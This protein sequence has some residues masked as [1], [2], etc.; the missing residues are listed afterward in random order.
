MALWGGGCDILH[1]H[2]IVERCQVMCYLTW[3]VLV[4]L[5]RLVGL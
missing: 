2:M 1:S 3:P 4:C 5:G